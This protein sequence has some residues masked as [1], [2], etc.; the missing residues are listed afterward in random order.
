M[1]E[2]KDFVNGHSKLTWNAKMVPEYSGKLL[3]EINS[4][5]FGNGKDKLPRN[6]HFLAETN[7]NSG[8]SAAV[9][10]IAFETA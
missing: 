2:L 6:L 3:S 1:A 7:S 8:V 10:K 5:S 9:K 4:R